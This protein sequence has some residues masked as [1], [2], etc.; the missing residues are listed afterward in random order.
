[1]LCVRP[2][3]VCCAGFLIAGCATSPSVPPRPLVV[4]QPAPN[5]IEAKRTEVVMVA[6]STLGVRYKWGGNHPK[7][8]LDCSGLVNYAYKKI[9]AKKLPRTSRALAKTGRPVARKDLKPGDLVFFNTIPKRPNS[10]VGIYIGQGKFI[11]APARGKKIR[12]DSLSNT[13]YAKR[14]SGARALL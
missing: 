10:H 14:Y 13:Y 6:L 1:M 5:P 12:I 11:N 3:L 9:H 8:G 4:R 2:L 7:E